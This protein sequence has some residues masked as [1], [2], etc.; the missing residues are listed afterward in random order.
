MQEV[1]GWTELMDASMA[2][3][4]A[5]GADEAAVRAAARSVPLAPEVIQVQQQ[6]PARSDRQHA[7]HLQ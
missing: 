1:V 2:A 3:A 6:Q 4:A 7:A 5:R